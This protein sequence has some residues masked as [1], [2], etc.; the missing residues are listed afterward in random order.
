[1][2]AIKVLLV[3]VGFCFLSNGYAMEDKKEQIAKD[4]SQ[5]KIS[6]DRA[7]SLAERVNNFEKTLLKD[8]RSMPEN[9]MLLD[10]Q[11]QQVI[12]FIKTAQNLSQQIVNDDSVSPRTKK[13]A[14][15]HMN[16]A[17]KILQ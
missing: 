8:E 11:A 13:E 12:D 14:E 2:K 5:V 9:I 10:R 6:L 4:L 17:S 16:V 3:V 7:K 1:M 15:A